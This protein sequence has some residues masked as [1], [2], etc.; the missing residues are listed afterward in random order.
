MFELSVMIILL[1]SCFCVLCK[2]TERD[3]KMSFHCI[4]T[5]WGYLYLICIGW[6]NWSKPS[7]YLTKKTLISHR[8]AILHVY[9]WQISIVFFMCWFLPVMSAAFHLP[10][11][12]S[13]GDSEQH[14]GALLSKTPFPTPSI[15]HIKERGE[16]GNHR[17]VVCE[18]RH[19]SYARDHPGV[20]ESTNP[21][22]R[23]K[24]WFRCSACRVYLCA[25]KERSCWSAWHDERWHDWEEAKKRQRFLAIQTNH[26][27]LRT[28]DLAARKDKSW[29]LVSN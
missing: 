21:F 27:L 9:I 24:T 23:R 4:T 26:V 29:L 16:G 10:E 5:H 14:L 6:H 19:Y 7:Y 2:W 1:L 22:K 20:T 3:I 25:K 28:S 11:F 8:V 15:M 12:G 13:Q 18:R 17:C